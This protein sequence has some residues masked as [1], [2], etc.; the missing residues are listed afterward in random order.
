MAEYRITY[1][2]DIPSQVEAFAGA[3]R[4][5]RPLSSRFQ[6]LIDAAAMR[7]GIIGTDAYVEAWR[8]SPVLSMPGTPN[9]VAEALAAGLEEQFTEIRDRALER[10]Q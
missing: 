9:E 4:V 8:M 2:R 3:E 5:R 1:W 10:L 6:E 7:H